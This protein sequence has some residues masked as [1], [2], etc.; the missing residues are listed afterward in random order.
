[1]V[2]SSNGS[3]KSLNEKAA[4]TSLL[5][6]KKVRKSR[7]WSG[8]IQSAGEIYDILLALRVTLTAPRTLSRSLVA[9]RLSRRIINRSVCLSARFIF[10]LYLTWLA[11]TRLIHPIDR[12]SVQKR[13]CEDTIQQPMWRLSIARCR[14]RQPEQPNKTERKLKQ[15]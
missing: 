4:F 1:M 8:Y 13:T 9:S 10:I 14:G 6:N 3:T 11:S 7:S 5:R 15:K 2:K 12:I